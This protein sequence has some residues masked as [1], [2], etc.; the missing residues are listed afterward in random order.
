MRTMS[1]VQLKTDKYTKYNVGGY[2]K[3]F[4][5]ILITIFDHRKEPPA[6]I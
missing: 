6:H 5:I 1:G 3:I 2:T 4:G